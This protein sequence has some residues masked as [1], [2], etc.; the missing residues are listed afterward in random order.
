METLTDLQKGMAA[1]LIDRTRERLDGPVEDLL[2][3]E[4]GLA[5]AVGE[6]SWKRSNAEDLNTLTAFC[7]RK[8][9]PPVSLLVVIP[10]LNKPEKG[11]L[12]HYFKRTL[13]PAEST[14]GW[15][16]ALQQIKDTPADVWEA[17]RGEVVDKVEEE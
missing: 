5:E 16:E 11:I 12:I 9:Y 2:V 8:G 4:G 15:K 10:G 17:F 1:A 3:A 7:D 13:S 6:R 14:K